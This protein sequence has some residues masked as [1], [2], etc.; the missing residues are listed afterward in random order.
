MSTVVPSQRM[1]DMNRSASTTHRA[2]VVIL[3]G[4]V[5]GLEA[6]L[7]LKDLADGLVDV[8]LIA[9]T[10]QF[11]FTPAGV[12]AP[13]G[14]AVVRQFD[15]F[16][17]AN[18]LGA[19]LIVDRAIAVDPSDRKVVLASG[20]NLDYDAL[21]V[22][23]GATASPVI[24]GAI[25]FGGHG[26]GDAV[27]S[28]LADLISGQAS[29]VLFAS[30]AAVGWT[31]PLYELS[32]L[33]SQYLGDRDAIWRYGNGSMRRESV[34]IGVVSPEP[35]PLATF[36][37][38]ASSEVGTV[39]AERGIEFYGDRTPMNF[40]DGRLATS[41]SGF[42]EADRV[43]ALPRL[44]GVA[45]DGIPADN[46]DLIRTDPHGRVNTLTSVYAAGDITTFPIKQG[47]IASQQALAAAKSIA[48]AVGA[49][50]SPEPFEPVLRGLL[51]TGGQERYLRTEV[52]GGHG[53]A[54][55]I[56]SEPLWWPPGKLAARYLTPYLAQL[57]VDSQRHLA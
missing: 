29:S 34:Q 56:D 4:G 43:V 39:L 37:A 19:R 18:D 8:T 35:M 57:D 44:R 54:A 25:T 22:A 12:A 21:L 16:R 9:A 20:T 31:L 38:E 28:V 55:A 45:I 5:A 36:G 17:I 26:S 53:P 33:T 48:A 15:L 7:A 49:A 14:R 11:T 10:D 13:F 42:I 6:A 50:V 2:R 46:D 24:S 1:A 30:P 52:E 27:R 3:G 23:C 41:P 40:R 47:G 51:L 32:L